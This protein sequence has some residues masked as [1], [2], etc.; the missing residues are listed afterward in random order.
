ML[1]PFLF[2]IISSIDDVFSRFLLRFC[3]V[4]ILSVCPSYVFLYF[5][6]YG[7]CHGRRRSLVVGVEC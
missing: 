1:P 5:A 6:L 4:E 3:G 7:K 2:L